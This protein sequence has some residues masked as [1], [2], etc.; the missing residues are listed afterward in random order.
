[1]DTG[2]SFSVCGR[3]KRK[4]PCSDL[5]RKSKEKN[6]SLK[7]HANDKHRDPANQFGAAPVPTHNNDNHPPREM[8][9]D[10]PIVARH[11]YGLSVEAVQ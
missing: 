1:M 7:Y 2:H 3:T 4:L 10:C 11:W 5:R 9:R 8:L 6:M